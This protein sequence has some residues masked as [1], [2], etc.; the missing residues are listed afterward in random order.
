MNWD[1]LRI[2]TA[3]HEHG[4]YAAAGKQLRLDETTVGRRV[5]R[6]EASLGFK[7]F[8]AH[9]GR[10]RLTRTAC[11]LL[12]HLEAMTRHADEITSIRS[13]ISTQGV[14]GRSRLATTNAL[15]EELLAPHLPALLLSNPNLTLEL[16]TSTQTVNFS[17]WEADLAIRLRKPRRGDYTISKLASIPLFLFEPTGCPIDPIVCCYPGELAETPETLFLMRKGLHQR[18]RCVTGSGRVIRSMIRAGSAA[19]VLPEYLCR[20]MRLDRSYRVTELPQQ[21]EIWLLIQGH[22]KRDPATRVIINWLRSSLARKP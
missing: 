2:L 11:G 19:G 20:D 17:R 6:L 10:R 8:D 16:Q 14:T 18:G 3:V 13:S 5:S 9:D 4:S 1:D 12:P 7:L 22:L 15:A 21:R